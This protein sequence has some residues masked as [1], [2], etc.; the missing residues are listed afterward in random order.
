M[1]GDESGEDDV[2]WERSLARK[3]G[4]GLAKSKT[5]QNY[6]PPVPLS[7]LPSYSACI[8]FLFPSSSYYHA[9]SARRHCACPLDKFLS[10]SS[11]YV[12]VLNSQVSN[13]F[14]GVTDTLL[15]APPTFIVFKYQLSIL[16]SLRPPSSP[17]PTAL[18]LQQGSFCILFQN[19]LTI[20]LCRIDYTGCS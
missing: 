17:S 15:A 12:F 8:V 16:T 1:K 14:A 10:R 18:G 6:F 9:S 3:E 13:H 5:K 2:R 20:L 7:E 11:Y 19:L 4:L